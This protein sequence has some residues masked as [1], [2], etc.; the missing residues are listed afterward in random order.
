MSESFRQVVGIIAAI[1]QSIIQADE[2]NNPYALRL[3]SKQ[4]QRAV[5]LFN[6]HVVS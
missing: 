2:K 3:L 4:Q 5:G 6:R 1:E